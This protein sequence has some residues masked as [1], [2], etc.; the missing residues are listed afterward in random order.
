MNKLLVKHP[1]HLFLIE[2]N[3]DLSSLSPCSIS[4]QHIS[5]SRNL[6]SI[7]V[8]QSSCIQQMRPFFFSLGSSSFDLF[9]SDLRNFL[10]QL[11]L[12][13]DSIQSRP[14]HFHIFF[15]STS[16]LD[17]L[18]RSNNP[19]FLVFSQTRDLISTRSVTAIFTDRDLQHSHTQTTGYQS[20]QCGSN[21]CGILK[22]IV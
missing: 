8:Y 15:C 3:Q 10:L 12:S 11:L 13:L 17:I 2:K 21:Q 20:S 6:F 4:F 18:F 7:N 19:Y 14:F 5:S 16:V 22:N 1:I 9:I